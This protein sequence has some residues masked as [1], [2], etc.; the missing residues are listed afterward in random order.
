M[1]EQPW[2]FAGPTEAG[3]GAS[4]A[5]VPIQQVSCWNGLIHF[6]LDLLT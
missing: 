2:E 4:L 3:V 6:F 1:S 5:P